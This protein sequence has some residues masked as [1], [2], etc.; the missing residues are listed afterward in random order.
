MSDELM[1]NP[2][3]PTIEINGKVYTMPLL[4]ANILATIENELGCGLSGLRELFQS[5]QMGTIRTLAWAILRDDYPELTIEE[6]G[7]VIKLKNL[8]EVS[9]K[10]FT[11]VE[12]SLSEK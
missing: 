9:D 7:K 2:K 1:K 12:L 10:I 8:S 4:N 3:T 6:V 11:V 5:K